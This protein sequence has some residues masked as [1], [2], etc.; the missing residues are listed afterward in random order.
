MDGKLT[1]FDVDLVRKIAKEL[2]LEPK[3]VDGDF[4]RLLDQVVTAELD[5][6]ASAIR[7]T[8]ERMQ[9]V[10]FTSPYYI[11]R[12]ALVVNSTR[13][14]EITSTEH[15]G[16]SHTLAVQDETTG[17]DWAG[18]NLVAARG[19]Q[20]KLVAEAPEMYDSLE[21]GTVTALITDEPFASIEVNNRSGLKVVQSIDIGDRY[22]FAVNPELTLLLED[23]NKALQKL[24]DDGTYDRLYAK[25]DKLGPNGSVTKNRP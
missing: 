10:D 24:I 8:E 15:L 19:V 4:D 13:T 7:V 17:G 21:R 16:A 12:Q 2:G 11:A 1:G 23:I 22:G 6:A 3:F 20:V 5:M 25:Y 14:P 9:K 18:S